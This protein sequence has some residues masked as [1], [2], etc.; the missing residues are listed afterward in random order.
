MTVGQTVF[1]GYG[2]S[3]VNRP[4]DFASPFRASVAE[5][6]S[7]AQEWLAARSSAAAWVRAYIVEQIDSGYIALAAWTP[8][9]PWESQE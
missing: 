1:V 3:A 7:D 4:P 9:V 8:S 5:A 2:Q 6:V